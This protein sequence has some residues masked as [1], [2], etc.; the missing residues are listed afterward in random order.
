MERRA[1]IDTKAKEVIQLPDQ[2]QINNF[3]V[4]FKEEQSTPLVGGIKGIKA[5]RVARDLIND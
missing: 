3:E 1:F 5:L 4:D 2:S